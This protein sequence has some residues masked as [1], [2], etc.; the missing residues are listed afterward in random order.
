[1][2]LQKRTHKYTI[3]SIFKTQFASRRS[4][5]FA[6]VYK[7]ILNSYFKTELYEL[8]AVNYLKQ[9]QIVPFKSFKM[10]FTQVSEFDLGFEIDGE[11]LLSPAEWS[12]NEEEEEEKLY[13][14]NSKLYGSNNKLPLKNSW[15]LQKPTN[16]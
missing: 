4:A 12:Y 15:D 13:G 16:K 6:L 7:K 11:I 1:M 5:Y 14:S 8:N 3:F 10:S 9:N 2:S